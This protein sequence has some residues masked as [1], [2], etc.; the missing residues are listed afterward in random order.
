MVFKNSRKL[1]F[2]HDLIILVDIINNIWLKTLQGQFEVSFIPLIKYILSS[3]FLRS[4]LNSA[5]AEY[6][7][8]Q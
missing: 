8:V 1:E 5:E 4:H 3:D 6:Y 7:W 2:G